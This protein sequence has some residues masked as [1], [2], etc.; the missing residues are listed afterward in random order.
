MRTSAT[1]LSTSALARSAQ[2]GFSLLE[3]AVVVAIIGIMVGLIQFSDYIVGADRQMRAEADRLRSLVDLLHEEALMQSRDFGLMFTETGYRFYVYDYKQAVWVETTD[4]ELLKQHPLPK[5]LNLVL[6]LD[7]REVK[8]N[9]DFGSRDIKN[10]EPQVMILS[11]GEITPFEASV[12]RN[13]EGGHFDLTAELDGTLTV[14]D[15]GF[16]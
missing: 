16:K 8:L 11:S 4:D 13:R 2:R 12:Y 6:A 7:D 9:P 1:G 5:L 14:S 15:D 3:V 10:P